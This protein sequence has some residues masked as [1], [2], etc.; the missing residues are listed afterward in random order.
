MNS[1]A[2]LPANPSATLAELGEFAVIDRFTA[3]RD[4]GAGTLLGPGDDAA[5]VS[6]P[7]GSVVVTTDMLVEGRHFRLDWSTPGDIG[8]KA[9]AQNAA[10]VA[11]MG[12]TTTSFVVAMGAPATTRADLLM[13]LADGMWA[14]AQAVGAGIVGGDLV[15]CPQ[16][17]ISVTAFGD[18]GGRRPVTRSGA[19][20]GSA[21]AVCGHLGRSA[22]G[23]ALLGRGLGGFDELRRS[24]RVPR[25]PYREGV[26]AAEHGASAMI[27]ISDGLI[28]DLRHVAVASAVGIEL[29]TGALD[30]DCAALADAARVVGADPLAWVLG[31][32]EEHALVAT[33]PGVIPAGW[34]VIGA[35]VDGPARVTVDGADWTGYAGW[36]SFG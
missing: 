10:D 28:A 30:V 9:I 26:V 27:D 12:A 7:G 23:F 6:A 21:V 1:G 11:A 13:E 32:G 34:R 19:R 24:H 16:W 5:V 29:S 18:L 15:A 14:E 3:G 33:F 36:R 35:V 22:A 31:G 8:R 2:E 25:P 17:V 4:F 20:A